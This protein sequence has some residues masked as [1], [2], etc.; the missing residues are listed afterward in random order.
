M[1]DEEGADVASEEDDNYEMMNDVEEKEPKGRGC[2]AQD[3]CSSKNSCSVT[4]RKQILE[5][6]LLEDECQITL[7]AKDKNI[8]GKS[9]CVNVCFCYC[10]F[11]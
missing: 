2:H 11:Y 5:V 1:E 3:K 6:Q 8:N 7:T 4:A 10:H 9:C